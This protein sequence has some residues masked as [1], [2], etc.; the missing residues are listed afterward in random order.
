MA[1]LNLSQIKQI[2]QETLEWKRKG[3]TTETL[4]AKTRLSDDI[5]SINANPLYKGA[6]GEKARLKAYGKAFKPVTDKH[7]EM[8]RKQKKARESLQTAVN[9]V[10]GAEPPAPSPTQQQLF[11]SAALEMRIASRTA[12]NAKQFF[13]AVDSLIAAAGDSA[14]LYRQID[15]DAILDGFDRVNAN[16]MGSNDTLANATDLKRVM[17]RLEE[18]RFTPE[19]HDAKALLDDA[20][21][22]E[23]PLYVK[24]LHDTAF[25]EQA[26]LAGASLRY[27]DANAKA[28][29]Q[30]PESYNLYLLALEQD[31]F[32][33]YV[34]ARKNG[35]ITDHEVNSNPKLQQFEDVIMVSDGR[36]SYEDTPDAE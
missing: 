32:A 13:A 6:D 22:F 14:A 35:R 1:K 10:L 30:T 36:K 17:A 20:A 25:A 2:K 5:I 16:K 33:S 7:A 31:D 28:A 18:G 8:L 23:A 34:A 12:S 19:Q 24:G 15:V 11:N 27:S 29:L 9:D 4:A 3:L 21:F 26:R